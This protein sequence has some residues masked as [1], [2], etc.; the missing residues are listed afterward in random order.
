M[1]VWFLSLIIF[2]I[3][4]IDLHISN[5]L[6][7]TGMNPTWSW[8]MIFLTCCLLQF[9]SVPFF[10]VSWTFWGLVEFFNGLVELRS[11]SIKSW[12]FLCWETLLLLQ[13]PCLVW[14]YSGSLYPFGS[15]L[16]VQMYPDLFPFL[17]D[18]LVYL[19]IGSWS[20]LGF[21]GVCYD[22]PIFI[23]NFN[24]GFFSSPCI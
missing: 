3:T 22:V 18:F 20:T 6:C 4:F 10:S 5:C 15:I 13:S 24:L 17:L 11:E 19:N 9:S 14:I 1:I 23:S 2:C 8:D 16:V 21:T 12:A 7:N